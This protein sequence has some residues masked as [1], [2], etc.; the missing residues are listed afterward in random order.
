MNHLRCIACSSAHNVTLFRGD[1]WCGYCVEE[2][3]Q[4]A[5]VEASALVSAILGERA[6]RTKEHSR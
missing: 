5:F 2:G 3:R 4:S 6:R 1:S